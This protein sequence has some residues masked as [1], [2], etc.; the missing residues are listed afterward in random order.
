MC[1]SIRMCVHMC[2]RMSVRNLC[3]TEGE[4]FKTCEKHKRNERVSEKRGRRVSNAKATTT[5]TLDRLRYFAADLIVYCHV[6]L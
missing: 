1:M 4:G 3:E 6:L 5:T 2:V